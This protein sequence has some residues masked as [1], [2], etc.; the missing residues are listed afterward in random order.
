MRCR[1][2]WRTEGEGIFKETV[3]MGSVVQRVRDGV[4]TEKGCGFFK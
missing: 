3:G 1:R 2:A 4:L